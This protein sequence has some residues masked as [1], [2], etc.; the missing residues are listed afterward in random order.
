MPP[1][2]MSNPVVSGPRSAP[3]I[4]GIFARSNPPTRKIGTVPRLRVGSSGIAVSDL[5]VNT[6]L[7]P[8]VVLQE[9][10][11]RAR[12]VDE[13]RDRTLIARGHGRTDEHAAAAQVV[14]GDAVRVG[15]RRGILPPYD[16][17]IAAT[18][19]GHVC[20][21]QELTADQGLD[22]H[23]DLPSDGREILD[24]GGHVLHFDP[25]ESQADPRGLPGA[26]SSPAAARSTRSRRAPG[27]SRRR[28]RTGR[29]LLRPGA[30]GRWPVASPP[31]PRRHL[32]SRR[33]A[34]PRRD[35]RDPRPRAPRGP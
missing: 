34:A 14:E 11:E 2:S 28:A 1:R 19:E 13:Q 23:P 21:P 6:R 18:V 15:R 16:E 10:R 33:G 4:A 20:V 17:L 22:R 5:H 31:R 9:E 3:A 29:R 35:G 24:Q 30:P 32:P 27:S 26:S 25:I 8:R 12:A 7:L